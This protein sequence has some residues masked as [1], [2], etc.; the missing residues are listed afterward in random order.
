VEAGSGDLTGLR[1]SRLRAEA[2]R[3]TLMPAMVHFCEA[4]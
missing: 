4:R 3:K 1:M 2:T